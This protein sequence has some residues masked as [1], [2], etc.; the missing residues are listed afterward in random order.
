MKTSTAT[1]ADC[2]LCRKSDCLEIVDW[3][4]ERK[5]G[6]EYHGEAVRCNRCDAIAPLRA[7][8]GLS[9]HQLRATKR[10]CAAARMDGPLRAAAPSRRDTVTR[11]KPQ[12]IPKTHF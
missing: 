4:H 9:R 1:L 6:T 8:M 10:H 7:W 5:D 3:I 11:M 12:L 2:P